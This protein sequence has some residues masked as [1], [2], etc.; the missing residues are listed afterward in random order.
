MAGSLGLFSVSVTPFD[1]FEEVD[2]DSLTRLCEFYIE[3]GVSALMSL[4]VMGEANRMSPAES[5]AI[6][7]HVL[8][9]VAGRIPVYFGASNPSLKVIEELA[10][11]VMENGAAGIMVT[12]LAQQKNDKAILS[13][14]KA[15]AKAVGPDVPLILQD[16]PQ[17]TET[18]LSVAL[19]SDIIQ[20]IPSLYIFKHEQ[21]P[22][23]AKLSALRDEEQPE[24]VRNIPILTGNGGLFLPQELARGASGAMTGFAFPE[25]MVQ[26]CALFAMDKKEAAEDLYDRYLPYLRY[27]HQPS[28]GLA[29]RKYVLYRRGIIA[30]YGTRMP[31]YKLYDT[32]V[33]EIERFLD[34]I[35][36]LE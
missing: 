8:K 20:A 27:E 34:R 6:S 1:K 2:Y 28:F 16:Y 19:I 25:V 14:F 26:V 22:G 9:V 12:P 3:K 5:I 7:R 13:Y 24:R 11:N 30:H 29:V 10:Q 33:A 15:V 23:L 35:G 21:W 31:G 36:A 18:H 4:G 17:Q 32:D